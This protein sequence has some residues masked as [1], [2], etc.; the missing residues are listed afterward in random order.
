MKKEDIMLLA[1]L[2][3]TMRDLVPKIKEYHK[4][5][6]IPKLLSVKKEFLK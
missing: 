6:D 1:Q 5:K 2:L 4:K 3:H